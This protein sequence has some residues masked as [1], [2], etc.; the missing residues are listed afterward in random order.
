MVQKS[1]QYKRKNNIKRYLQRSISPFLVHCVLSPIR[2]PRLSRLCVFFQE[3]FMQVQQ[4][5]CVRVCVP[6][7]VC[8]DGTWALSEE[9]KGTHCTPS[10][11]DLGNKWKGCP[12]WVVKRRKKMIAVWRVGYRFGGKRLHTQAHSHTQTCTHTHRGLCVHT[13][14]PGDQFL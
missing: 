5:V 1:K 14:A 7:C 4:C 13:P 3:F 2:G 6:V 8:I 10:V 11:S 9:G 12:S